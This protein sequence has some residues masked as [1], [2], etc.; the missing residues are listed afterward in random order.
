MST[1]RRIRQ[2]EKVTVQDNVVPP[3]AAS[4][5]IIENTLGFRVFRPQFNLQNNDVLS[6]YFASIITTTV[7]M[8][9]IVLALVPSSFAIVD[10]LI[11]DLIVPCTNSKFVF[12]E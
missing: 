10:D 7:M 3:M 8:M 2:D 4:I 9:M 1:R 5:A 11:D 6:F 12:L